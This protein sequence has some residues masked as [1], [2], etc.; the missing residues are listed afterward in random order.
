M[1]SI[2]SSISSSEVVSQCFEEILLVGDLRI[3]L[4]DSARLQNMSVIGII[5]RWKNTGLFLLLLPCYL[6]FFSGET[7][8]Y[9]VG[10]EARDFPACIL[11]I[12]FR[13]NGIDDR[14]IVIEC[15]NH[16]YQDQLTCY[17]AHIYYSSSVQEM[18]AFPFFSHFGTLIT[19]PFV[20]ENNII[21]V[22]C[23]GL[24]PF[25]K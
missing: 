1:L 21:V 6:L 10:I 23:L 3:E 13:V 18:K 19:L 25:E 24:G 22:F 4:G 14:K 7:E 2:R 9:A 8:K 16:I 20:L 17:A 15:T 11:R 12:L 5:N